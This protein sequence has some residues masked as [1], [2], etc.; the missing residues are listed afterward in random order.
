MI[1]TI[2]FA[3]FIVL[4]AF[5]SSTE[6]ALFSLSKPKLRRMADHY[7]YQTKIIN[8]L[9]Q[10]P[11][12]LLTTINFGNM[13]VNTGIASLFTALFVSLYG[14]RGLVLS[15]IVSTAFILILGEVVPKT[16]A[17]YMA[18]K[19]ALWSSPPL[20]AFSQVLRPLT[21]II[22]KASNSLSPFLGGY[23][24]KTSYST[25][26]LKT[27]LSIS[28]QDGLISENEEEMISHILEFKDTWVEDILIPRT[29]IHGIDNQLS[30]HEVIKQV[31]SSKNSKLPVYQDSLDNIVGI[32]YAK[33]LLLNPH[34]DYRELL[35]APLLVPQ[36]R[37]ID[38]LLKDFTARRESI[39]IVLDE[40]GGTAGMLTLEDIEEELFGEIYDEFETA[41]PNIEKIDSKTYRIMGKTSVKEI[42]LELE[43]DLPD[44]E[45]TLAGF[46][47]SR[48]EKIPKPQEKLAY[49][50]I[51]FI[52]EKAT[53]KRIVSLLVKFSK[54]PK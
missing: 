1:S 46:I 38:D 51:E 39:A 18:E 45:V 52:V 30:Q 43:L 36:S 25:E 42:N 6:T 10:K 31:R 40:Y 13:L 23:V 44:E 54:K 24:H 50:N 14:E 20:K 19:V 32:L 28:K 4:S 12:R 53:T 11:T 47:L 2:L 22:E 16:I 7:P 34:H 48:M 9:L 21:F 33:D 5:F 15:V 26:E 41:R 27:A 29:E 35:R 49:N 8:N 17:I 3:I 37:R